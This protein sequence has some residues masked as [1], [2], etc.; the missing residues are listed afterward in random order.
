LVVYADSSFLVAVYVEGGNTEDATGYFAKNP[1]PICLTS[2][3][4]SEAQHAIRMLAFQKQIAF[5]EMTRSLLQFERD[6]AEGFYEM[7]P[8]QPQ[9]LFLKTSQLSNRHAIEFGIRYLDMLH[10][11]AALLLKA[12]HFLTLDARQGKL[13]KAVGLEVRP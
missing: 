9:D 4:K 1:Q 11:S 5:A 6:E 2:F 8:L 13:A 10:V 7:Q 3:S 12:T